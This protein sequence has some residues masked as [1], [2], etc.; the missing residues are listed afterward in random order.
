MTYEQY[1]SCTLAPAHVKMNQYVRA[2]VQALLV[3]GILVA[4]A[5]ATGELWCLFPA[6]AAMAA[7]WGIAYCQ[8]WLHDRLI[9]LSAGVDQT[10]VGMVISNER[11]EDKHDI[12]GRLDTDFSINLLLPP[13]PPDA[14]SPTVWRSSPY[15]CLVRENDQTKNEHLIFTGHRAKDETGTGEKSEALHG[16]FEGGGITDFLLACQ[17]ALGLAIAGLILCEVLGPGLGAVLGIILAALALLAA[18]FGLL[19]GPGDTGS[20]ED[21]GLPSIETNTNAGRG[22]DILGI[23]G[24]WV[25][26]S[27]HNNEN[28][29]WNE[30]H[31]IK[32]ASKLATWRGTWDNL[33]SNG[34]PVGIDDLINDWQ[35]K[36]AEASSAGTIATQD[37]PK[38][39]WEIHPLIDGCDDREQ[40]HG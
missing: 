10:A 5:L 38:N 13:N 28:K 3:G 30:I 15:G 35:E 39:H 37:E 24:R 19:F 33:T 36:V 21:V 14:D 40:P 9:C 2:T 31:P 16:E 11:P 32:M 25:Y 22:A 1:T 7:I 20:P 23:A 8:W 4:I 34:T 18:L 17:I 26:D 6:G 29:G 27:G 12:F